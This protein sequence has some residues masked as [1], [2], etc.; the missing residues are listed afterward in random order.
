MEKFKSGAGEVSSR[1]KEPAKKH[2]K[3]GRFGVQSTPANVRESPILKAQMVLK[4]VFYRIAENST[5]SF[6]KFITNFRISLFFGLFCLF[7]R[8]KNAT[9][10]PYM[11]Q[12]A[13]NPSKPFVFGS[14]LTFE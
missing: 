1:A 4:W 7:K 9:F 14:S 11:V 13:K 10:S 12:I 5:E 8:W 2:Q 6:V 3:S